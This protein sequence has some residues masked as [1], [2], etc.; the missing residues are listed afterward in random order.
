MNQL[1]HCFRVSIVKIMEVY[2]DLFNIIHLITQLTQ[3]QIPCKSKSKNIG[4]VWLELSCIW[5][6]LF[7]F[8]CLLQDLSFTWS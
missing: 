1:D 6:K 5:L 8:L 2:A 4:E 7:D 3:L